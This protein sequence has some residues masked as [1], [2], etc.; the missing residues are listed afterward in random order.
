[1]L[2]AL[3]HEDHHTEAEFVECLDV[4][5]QD[6]IWHE[7]RDKNRTQLLAEIARLRKQLKEKA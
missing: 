6:G 4:Y 1:M 5:R 3:C 2:C 7:F